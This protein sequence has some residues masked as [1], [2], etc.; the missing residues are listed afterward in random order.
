[1]ETLAWLGITPKQA[2]AI[3]LGLEPS[4]YYRSI[5]LEPNERGEELCEFGVEV[6]GQEVYVKLMI[7][8]ATQR[9]VCVSFHIPRW[10]LS[11]SEG[12]EVR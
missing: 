5:S 9:A 3:V 12:G 4:N 1:M 10:P 2:R 11:S 6:E 8:N 7:D